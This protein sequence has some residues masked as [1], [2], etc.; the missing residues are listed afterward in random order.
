MKYRVLGRTGLRV[1]ELAL[2][3]GTIGTGWGWGAEKDESRAIFDAFAEAGG[4]FIDCAAGYQGGEAERFLGEFIARDRDAF[5]ISTKYGGGPS[6]DA[7]VAKAGANAKSL[8][9]SLEGSLKRFGVERVDL[10][11]V[12]FDDGV[13]PTEEVLRALEEA[14]RAGKT[15]YIGFSNFPA[16][17]I[18]RAATISELRGGPP[19][20]A[21][22]LEYSLI[23]RSVE[24]ELLPMAEALGIGVTVW[25]AL[26]GGLL[27]GKYRRGGEGRLTRG[28]GRV[29]TESTPRETA[30]LDAL[31]AVAADLGAPMSQVAIAWV[32]AKAARSA[33]AI[34]PILGART[35]DQLREN[36]GALEL[37]LA[38]EH[39]EQLDAASAIPLGYPHE[40]LASDTVRKL[41]EGSA[42]GR[43]AAPPRPV[44]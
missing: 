32:L 6:M 20:A 29:L 43:V 39:L 21:I 44:A 40:W 7:P 2:G 9:Q 4:N 31:E 42:F 3:G 17:R 8:I 14:V 16:W 36:L 15:S 30:I 19:I 33:T 10:S 27:T 24:R 11:Y 18:A 41:G 26:G 25:A 38:D 35:L 28:G 5:I 22:E 34:V 13:T 12:H 23:E 37:A 1:S